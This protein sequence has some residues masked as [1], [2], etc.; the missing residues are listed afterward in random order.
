M[1]IL[2]GK[3]FSEYGLENVNDSRALTQVRQTEEF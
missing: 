3:V 2:E 1:H